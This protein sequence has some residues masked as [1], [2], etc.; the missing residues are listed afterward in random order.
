MRGRHAINQQVP[1]ARE[2][3]ERGKGTPLTDLER[4]CRHYG[5]TEEEYLSCPECYPLPPRGTGLYRE[6]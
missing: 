2:A 4:A 3:E 5:I 6:K 1:G